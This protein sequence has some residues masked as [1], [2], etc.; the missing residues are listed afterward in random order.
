MTHANAGTKW[1]WE[2]HRYINEKAV[3]YLPAEMAFWADQKSFLREHG[4]DPDQDDNPGYYHYIDIDRYPEF[5][6]GTLPHEWQDMISQYGYNTV[7]D[8]GTVPWVIEQWSDSLTHLMQRGEWNAAW[9]VAAELGHY[10]ADSHQALH[11]TENYNGQ[12]T[13]NYGIHSRYET[14]MTTPYLPLLSLPT[15]EA[16]YWQSTL[17]S[18]FAWIDV[19]YPYVNDIMNADDAAYSIDPS[20][21]SAYYTKLWQLLEYQTTDAIHRAIVDLA[22]VWYTAWVNAGSPNPFSGLEDGEPLPVQFAMSVFPN[23]FN[24]QTQIA[25]QVQPGKNLEVAL[26]DVVGRQVAELYDG[27]VSGNTMQLYWNGTAAGAGRLSSG[28][29]FVIARQGAHVLRQKI[30]LLK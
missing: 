21:G 23:P 18:V 25:L 17:D 8:N 10:V 29:Y 4:V 7:L 22:S 15:G 2:V 28:T 16:Q 13:G 24:P 30:V 1:G 20:Y 12:L 11:L 9:Q 6:N 19:I 14:Q 5:A 27:R 26:Y 3:D